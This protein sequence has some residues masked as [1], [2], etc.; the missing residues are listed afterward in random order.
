M[1][2]TTLNHIL[3]HCLDKHPRDDAFACRAGGVYRPVS[4]ERFARKVRLLG[5]GLLALGVKRGSKVALLS[6][7]RLEWAIA[8]FSILSIGAV[9]VP[10][11]STLPPSQVLHIL[12][13]S[14]AEVIV[15]SNRSQLEKIQAISDRLH[16]DLTVAVMDPEGEMNDSITPLDRVYEW[17]K[18]LEERDPALFSRLSATTTSRDIATIIYTSGTTGPPQGVMLTHRNIMSNI[19]SVL[20]QIPIERSDKVLSFLPLSHILERMAGFYTILY[21][22][23]GIAYAGSTDTIREDIVAA[24]PTL[25]I[26]VPRFLE[27]VYENIRETM[28]ASSAFRRKIFEWSIDVGHKH[29][30]RTRTHGTKGRDR[31]V[32]YKIAKRLVFSRLRKEL[33]GKVRFF[34][35]GGAPLPLPIAEFFHAVGLP[36]YEGYGLTET[37]PVISCNSP[38]EWKLGSVGRPISGVDVMTDLN[39]EILVRGPNVMIGYFGKETETKEALRG[40]WFHTGDVGTIDED[41]FLH[42]TDRKKDLIITSGGKNIAPQPIEMLLKQS[43]FIKEVVLIGNGRKFI[44]ALIVPDFGKI[45]PVVG[46]GELNLGAPGILAENPKVRKVIEEEIEELSHDLAP[47]EQVKKFLL[48]A[49]NF[50]IGTGEL[51]PTLKV[52][53]DIVE[54]EYRHLIDSMYP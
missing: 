22:G 6:E 7:N 48:I 17:G 42:I 39:G 3:E 28:A 10:I 11:Y 32:K 20:E 4:T 34:I 24:S 36:V 47:H 33:G 38:L 29:L 46:E 9:N 50:R 13:D 43:K 45:G 21:A 16:C 1:P 25:M 54:K 44:S 15:A 49:R 2:V 53:R 23:A 41:G 27:K 5:L 35:C 30:E 18:S 26:T 40:G 51:T 12:R 31:S 8:D 14:K 19:E 37:S 52:K